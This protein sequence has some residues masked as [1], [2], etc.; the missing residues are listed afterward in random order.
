M[1][2]RMETY[3]ANP[4]KVVDTIAKNVKKAKKQLKKE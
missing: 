4:N 2:K 3:Y 1:L